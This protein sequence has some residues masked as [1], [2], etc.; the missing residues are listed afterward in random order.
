MSYYLS[1]LMA[2]LA[3]LWKAIPWAEDDEDGP[4][5]N[6]CIPNANAPGPENYYG[7]IDRPG[8]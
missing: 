4:C 6:H 1:A 8:Y 7:A 5:A 2:R 3:S